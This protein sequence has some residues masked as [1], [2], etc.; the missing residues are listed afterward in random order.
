MAISQEQQVDTH[1]EIG[2]SHMDL[3]AYPIPVTEHTVRVND[4]DIWYVE[5]GQGMPLLLLHGGPGSNGP[6]WSDSVYGWPTY[7]DVFAP[8]FRVIAPDTR[9]HG[10]TR[11]P[12]GVM[13]WERFAQDVIALAEALELDHP[14][15]CGM[16]DGGRIADLVGILAPDLLRA[17][18]DLAGN[19]PFN[20]DPGASFYQAARAW[21]GGHP[22]AT[23]VDY[24]QLRAGDPSFWERVE[25]DYEPTQGAGYVKRYLEQCFPIWTT[26]MAYSWEDFARITAPTLL[27]VGDRD[28]F[29]P[30]DQALSAFRQLRQGEFGVLPGADHQIT[31]LACT[32]IVDF[33]LRQRG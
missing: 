7:F 25:Q 23:S 16:S 17:I 32:L 6:L 20:P 8:H 33:L 31:P 28:Q 10:R 18:V 1:R 19:A 5:C 11:N 22:R 3:S 29:L 12:S 21:A 15:I 30:V 27:L 9:G 24:N 13:H 4:L 2:T 26:P 14:L